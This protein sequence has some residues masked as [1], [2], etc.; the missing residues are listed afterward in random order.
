V[1]K[2]YDNRV[3]RCKAGHL[4]P[5]PPK[6]GTRCLEC[7]PPD[8]VVH[9][10]QLKD[11]NVTGYQ[12]VPI[13]PD[14]VLDLGA[15]TLETAVL[16]DPL[17]ESGRPGPEGARTPPTAH[18]AIK[19]CNSCPVIDACRADAHQWER[20]GVYGGEYMSITYHNARRKSAR[21]AAD[22]I[23]PAQEDPLTINLR[24]AIAAIGTSA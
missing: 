22:P 20:V 17:G 24:E 5:S 6:R 19:I 18:S 2:K 16:F 21:H 3:R 10:G 14:D 11:N 15:C 9:R 12:R 7:Y 13:P 4:M 23:V 8:V 1:P